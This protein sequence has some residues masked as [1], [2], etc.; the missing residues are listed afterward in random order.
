VLVAGFM[1]LSFLAYSSTLKIHI[2]SSSETPLDFEQT[3]WCDIPEDRNIQVHN[4]QSL[5]RRSEVIT[6]LIDN[7]YRNACQQHFKQLINFEVSFQKVGGGGE[8]KS[9]SFYFIYDFKIG[10]KSFRLTVL[11]Q[12]LSIPQR[13]H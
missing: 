8:T 2:T 5:P 11:W 3:T 10:F 1:L 9:A 4:N 6:S 7:F 12:L 13:C